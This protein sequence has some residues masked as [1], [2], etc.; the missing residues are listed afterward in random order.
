M[1]KTINKLKTV[2]SHSFPPPKDE[3][4]N[5]LKLI[6]NI[7]ANPNKS[8]LEKQKIIQKLLKLITN[9]IQI[10][11][12]ETVLFHGKKE[13]NFKVFHFNQILPFSFVDYPSEITPYY[14]TINQTPCFSLVW[15]SDRILNAF[16]NI[17]KQGFNFQKQD[18]PENVI[19]HPLGI[20]VGF[21]NNHS[22]NA[23]LLENAGQGKINYEMTLT[24]EKLLEVLKNSKSQIDCPEITLLL[25]IAQLFIAHDFKIENN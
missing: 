12:N 6:E 13:N 7:L 9:K 14:F 11:Y 8:E 4:S 22:T 23:G 17:G 5:Y 16:S 18:N 21:G 1:L 25:K 24:S 15:R 10:Y 3:T 2:L 19:V 20:V